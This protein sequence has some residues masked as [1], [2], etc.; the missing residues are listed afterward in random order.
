MRHERNINLGEK[1]AGFAVEVA[2]TDIPGRGAMAF[3][4]RHD[5]LLA[6]VCAERVSFAKNARVDENKCT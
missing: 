2:D 1:H 4:P 5:E 3:I 6:I